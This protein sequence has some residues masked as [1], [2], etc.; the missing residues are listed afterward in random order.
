MPVRLHHIVAGAHDLPGLARFWTQAPGWMILSEREIVIGTEEVAPAG[1][2]FLPVT[3][4]K[5]ERNRVHPDLT[6]SA[7]DRD[8]EIGR[9]L[10]L[11]PRRAGIVQTGAESWTVLAD[12]K[13][14]SSA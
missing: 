6:S 7:Q 9:L 13:E 14:T 4:P 3:D 2:C 5:T 1:M 8:Q 11:G 10:A 12:P